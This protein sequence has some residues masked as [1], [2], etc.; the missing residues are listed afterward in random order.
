MRFS[1]TI[2]RTALAF[3]LLCGSAAESAPDREPVVVTTLADPESDLVAVDPE[4][5]SVEDR[6]KIFTQAISQA[7]ATERQA[8]AERCRSIREIPATGARREVWEANC[9]YQRR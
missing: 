1:R 9:R 4:E 6:I 5:P 8:I 3:A 2:E 7:A